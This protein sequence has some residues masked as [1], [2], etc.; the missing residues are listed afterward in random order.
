[1]SREDAKQLTILRRL[2]WTLGRPATAL[3][4]VGLAACNTATTG[5]TPPPTT[6]AP[7]GRVA[8]APLTAPGGGQVDM[9][10]RWVLASPNA[11]FCNMNFSGKPGTLEGAIAPEGGCPGNFFTSR[12]WAFEQSALVIRNHKGEPLAQLSAA[13]PTRLEGQATSGE[14]ITL[15]R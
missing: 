3:L 9:V 1:M 11:G 10:G 13:A 14:Q 5:T 15:S 4:L 8:A 12:K 2:G 7:S 6:A